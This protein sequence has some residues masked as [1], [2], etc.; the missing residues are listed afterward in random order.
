[1]ILFWAGLLALATLL[2]VLLD[3]FDL[4]VGILFAFAGETDR[5]KM[6]SAISPVWDGNETWLV[7]TGTVSAFVFGVEGDFDW[8]NIKGNPSACVGCQV[9][10]SW[11]A[12]ARGRVGVAWDRL[13]FYGTGGAAFQNVKFAVTAPPLTTSLATVEFAISPNWSVKAEYL[14]VNFNN[15]TIGP[16]TFTLIE[17]VVRGGVN[18]R[19]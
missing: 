17:N 9:S 11:F 18:Y 14:Y 7:V 19:F 1:M 3:G 10:S 5:R 13:L 15:Q 8:D 16:G 4:G 2:Y 6:L 12:T